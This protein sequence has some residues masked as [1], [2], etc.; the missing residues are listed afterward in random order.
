MSVEQKPAVQ[1]NRN[2]LWW[3]SPCRRP[4]ANGKRTRVQTLADQEWQR[5]AVFLGGSREQSRARRWGSFPEGCRGGQE[6]PEGFA[7]SD[8]VAG[9]FTSRKKERTRQGICGRGSGEGYVRFTMSYGE[10][11]INFVVPKTLLACTFP[12][13]HCIII[14]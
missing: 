14:F 1:L 5:C 13:H 11:N 2:S 3:C 9:N 8:Y 12:A 6:R 4:T 10:L 7:R